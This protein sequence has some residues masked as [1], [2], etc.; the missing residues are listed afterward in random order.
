MGAAK[1]S[2]EHNWSHRELWAPAFKVENFGSATDSGDSAIAGL[3]SAFLRGL[4]IESA[5]KY[6]TCCS[7][8]NVRSLDA[9]SGIKSWQETT[10][11]I[12]D[13]LPLIDLH[14]NST[15]WKWNEKYKLWSGPYD[16][17]TKNLT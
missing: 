17:H 13:D 9:V 11:M 5:L 2:N 12:A 8:Q 16:S 7:L 10:T 4:V 14:I 1:P 6:A 15:G 3:L